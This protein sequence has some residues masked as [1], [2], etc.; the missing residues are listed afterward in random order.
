MKRKLSNSRTAA[1]RRNKRRIINFLEAF[2]PDDCPP[3][4]LNYLRLQDDDQGNSSTA[5]EDS[6]RTNN[7]V[8]VQFN[9]RDDSIIIDNNDLNVHDDDDDNRDGGNIEYNN[10]GDNAIVTNDNN[11]NLDVNDDHNVDRYE[12]NNNDAYDDDDDAGG[13][14]NDNNDSN[15]EQ[16]DQVNVLHTPF[17]S[18]DGITDNVLLAKD[19]I[20]IKDHILSAIAMS[21]RHKLSYEATIDQLKWLK[22]IYHENSIPTDKNQLW[23]CLNK[24]DNCLT[25]HYYC[26][27]CRDY[28]G[29]KCK[30]SGKLQKQCACKSCGP[31]DELEANLCYFIY[32]SLTAQLKELFSIPNI[33]E[34]LKYRFRRIKRDPDA[35]ED[36]YDG[37][38]YKLLSSPGKFLNKW[39]NLSFTINTDGC[40]TTKSSNCSAW[41]V[42]AMIN[43]LS[44]Q[45][46]KKHMLLVAIY[47]DAQ[48]P[49]MNYFLRPFTDEIQILFTT[50]IKWKPSATSEII[51]R[52]MV[53]TCS[54]DA[55]ARASVTSMIQYNGRNGCLWCYAKGK[56]LGPGKFVYPFCQ[57][58]K[59]QRT[60]AE[61]RNDM[62]YA[63]DTG[64]IRH[65]VKNI[66]SL[67]ALPLFNICNG[68]VVEAMHAVYLGVVKRHT[69]ILMD[70][71]FSP[72]ACKSKARKTK[73]PYY[74]GDFNSR[75]LID[76]RLLSIKPPSCR[77]RRPRSIS[78]Y[79]KWK[80]SEWR[81]WLD[82][83]PSCLQ[84]I[85]PVKYVNHLALLSEAIHHLNSDSISHAN[86]DRCERLLKKYVKLF[87]QYFGE[88]NMT[89]NLHTLTHLVKVVRDWGPIWVHEAFVFE[90]WNRKILE[91]VTSSFAPTEQIATR[92]LMYRFLITSMYKNA[93]SSETK[94]FVFKLIK[95]SPGKNNNKDKLIGLGKQV[96]CPP[97]EDQRTELIRAGFNPINLIHFKKMKINGARYMCKK[98]K[99]LKFD[100]TVVCNGNGEF[101]VVEAIVKFLNGSSV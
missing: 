36:I 48:H 21:V 44:P 47:V 41:P 98:E 55:P 57:C 58:Y 45:L 69:E 1:Y 27:I 95:I 94:R 59:K 43:E 18:I 70:L 71:K 8:T 63:F 61:V 96:I 93:V 38:Q 5:Q 13:S 26:Q 39:F 54:L 62:L 52:F 101:G 10:Y 72:K 46:R 37:D 66:S 79:Q 83:A 14:S 86:L 67:V 82:Y 91:Y 88:V 4:P 100:D 2:H 17:L 76:R 65:G 31:D 25:R 50:G 51:S 24:N 23:T 80:A 90:S 11:D 64:K 9:E 6:N 97:T 34:L 49:M 33:S 30:E 32:I 22:T 74:V 99:N 92:F 81:N 3:I 42:Y 89:S 15:N 28:L 29:E 19:N 77:S 7:E 68:V 84:N 75:K 78:T 35:Y 20:N 40:Q 87:Q 73:P 53:T 85:L 16:H 60:D 12:N 56:S